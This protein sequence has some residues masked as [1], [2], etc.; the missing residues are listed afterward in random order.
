MNCP[1]CGAVYNDSSNF[2]PSCGTALKQTSPEEIRQEAPAGVVPE[3]AEEVRT[4]TAA[5]EASEPDKKKKKKKSVVGKIVLA[6]ALVLI[7]ALVA[8]AAF[9]IF[10]FVLPSS[11]IPE[12]SEWNLFY[13]DEK[14][15]T[16]L[17]LD[18][19]Y[20][21]DVE[22]AGKVEKECTS[23]DGRVRLLTSDDGT[24]YA[25]DKSGLKKI[26][27]E[28]EDGIVLSDN[29][30]MVA[31][32][33]S[34]GTLFLFD[35]KREERYK[36]AANAEEDGY[37]L[38]PDGKALVYTVES[39]S[40]KDTDLVLWS[41]DSTQ[42]IANDVIP[43]AVSDKARYLYYLDPSENALYVSDSK[44]ESS[45]ISKDVLPEYRFIFN[46]NY[47]E[48]LF[49][50]SDLKTYISRKGGEKEKILSKILFPLNIYEASMNGF[51]NQWNDI[52]WRLPART[53]V[54]QSY[55]SG[56]GELYYVD[57]YLDAIKIAS[58]VPAELYT[59]GK[60]ICYKKDSSLFYT[61]SS[62]DASPEKIAHNIGDYV[63]T[64]DSG[65]IFYIN[66]N[67]ELML[68]RKG[69]VEPERIA[70][71][72]KEFVVSDD[73]NYIYFRNSDDMLL[74]CRNKKKAVKI[75]DDVLDFYIT[76]DGKYCAFTAIKNSEPS[77]FFVK[78][79]RKAEKIV[80]NPEAFSLSKD[81]K[82][83]CYTSEDDE[84]VFID[85]RHNFRKIAKFTN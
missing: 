83:L 43:I 24:L 74:L 1:N 19:H 53:L 52:C 6:L 20:L 5:V 29:G 48:I 67:D 72:V 85:T 76:D 25:V 23:Y 26:S 22:I 61:E 11:K 10:K 2:C 55:Y 13:N 84:L 7:L 64:K 33:N 79:G 75:A 81:G 49:L 80:T 66:S 57:R 73:G 32:R 41:K 9:C 58:G 51:D 30:N 50:T 18:G 70:N 4:E 12:V 37:V 71:D 77:L 56:E 17:S 45:K 14:D 54:N 28:A 15:I 3:T 39:K 31:Y 60:L 27:T 8:A 82:E 38:S 62:A 59:N 78:A 21:K 40:N 42:I 69:D 35:L 44:G 63:M 65:D 47:S 68:I 16:L 36:I 46:R 34:D